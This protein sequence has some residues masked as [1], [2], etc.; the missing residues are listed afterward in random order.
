MPRA[1]VGLGPVRVGSNCLVSAIGGLLLFV[2]SGYI[3]SKVRQ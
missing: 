3:I 1:S 2:V